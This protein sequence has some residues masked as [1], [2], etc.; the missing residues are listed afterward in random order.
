MND[1]W[2]YQGTG[3]PHQGIINL[4]LPPY[5]RRPRSSAPVAGIDDLLVDP[6]LTEY[7]QKAKFR[8]SQREI[9]AVNTAIY[10]RRPLLVTGPPGTG[11]S[12]LAYAITHELQLGEVLEWRITTRSTLHDAL[13]RYDAIGRLQEANLKRDTDR[14]PPQIGQFIRLGPLGTAF[15]PSKYPRVLLIDEID[16]SDIDLPNDLLHILEQGE[17]EINELSR[18]A[19][20]QPETDV[21]CH[22]TERKQVTISHGKVSCHAFPIVIMTSNG[23]RAFPPPFLRRCIR[24]DFAVPDVQ[25]LRQIVDTYFEDTNETVRNRNEDLIQ[26]FLKTREEK[27][28]LATDQLLNAIYLAGNGVNLLTKEQLIDLVLQPLSRFNSI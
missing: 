6:K 10:L 16:K 27:G 24:L 25:K 8:V 18:I 2:I 21:F 3:V 14:D 15:L 13:Y 11:K 9:E 26:E 7:F 23:E 12:T 4:P 5:W 19:D 1:W 22:A 17:F 28:H 20:Q